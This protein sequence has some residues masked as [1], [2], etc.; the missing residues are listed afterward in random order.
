VQSLRIPQT[1]G[2]LLIVRTG[3]IVTAHIT[4]PK[5]GCIN[6]R[7]PPDARGFQHIARFNNGLG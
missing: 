6:E 5:M 3:R 2:F 1:R 7:V 4:T